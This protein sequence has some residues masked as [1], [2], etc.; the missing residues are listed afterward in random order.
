MNA[1]LPELGAR[2]PP[3]SL[4]GYLNF[5]DGRPDAKF[6]RAFNQAYAVLLDSGIPTPWLTL[7]EWL[8]RCAVELSE[9]GSSAFL[10]VSQARAVIQADVDRLY[11]EFCG[12]VAANRGL[13]NIRSVGERNGRPARHLRFHS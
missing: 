8:D 4:L 5:S 7:G 2:V 3:Q 10:D 11:A 6:Q 1:N 9:T 12:L 13:T